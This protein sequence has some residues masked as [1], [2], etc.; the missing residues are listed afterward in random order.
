MLAVEN[1]HLTQTRIDR[2]DVDAYV[3]LHKSK[4]ERD[5]SKLQVSLRGSLN[6]EAF[7][8]AVDKITALGYVDF[9][10]IKSTDGRK[11]NGKSYFPLA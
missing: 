10:N 8:Y 7:K 2:S 3:E 1:K 9:W 5:V 11:H 6:A 4:G